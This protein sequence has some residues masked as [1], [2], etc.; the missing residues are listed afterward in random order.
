MPRRAVVC[1][2]FVL[3]GASADSLMAQQETGA[4]GVL[5]DV[6]AHHLYIHC[7]G[8]ADAGPTV[9]LEAGAGDISNRWSTVQDLLASRVRTCAYDR[10]GSGRSEPGPS[11]RTMRQEVFELDAL[12]DAVELSGPFVVVGHSMGSFLVRL[13]TE[14]Y[15]TKVI[16]VVLVDPT[17]ENSR[18]VLIL[19]GESQL[20]LVRVREQATGRAVPEPRPEG[21]VSTQYDPADDFLAEEF[22]QIYL[23]RQVNPTPLGNRPLIVVEGARPRPVPPGAS[24]MEWNDLQQEKSAENA[25]LVG[26]SRNSKLVRDPSSGHDVHVDNPPLVARAIEQV[27]EAAVMGT[28]LNP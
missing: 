14:Q 10:A 12:L 5:V 16:G 15:P 3:L 27:I 21:R 11:P 26:L 20:R 4:A 9:I 22:Q 8:P 2:L 19:P 28:S 18:Q 6:G 24:E 1:T 25:D 23:S 17:H 7:V 13:Y